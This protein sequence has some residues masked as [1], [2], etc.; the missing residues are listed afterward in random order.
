M[1]TEFPYVLPGRGAADRN[2]TFFPSEFFRKKFPNIYGVLLEGSFPIY[3]FLSHGVRYDAFSPVVCT[4]T[5]GKAEENGDV[6]AKLLTTPY[7]EC[8]SENGHLKIV[9]SELFFALLLYW[10]VFGKK[11]IL[12]DVFRIYP[13]CRNDRKILYH[14]LCPSSAMLLKGAVVRENV[15]SCKR[16]VPFLFTERKKKRRSRT[17]GTLS[18]RSVF[19]FKWKAPP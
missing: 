9:Q 19:P 12:S 16:L 2:G 5:P 13:F 8:I 11:G 1:R 6:D 17:K 15:C 18:P 14:L 4:S 7:L 10:N 3:V